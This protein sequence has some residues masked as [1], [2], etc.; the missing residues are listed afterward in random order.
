MQTVNKAVIFESG[1]EEYAVPIESV[2]SIEKVDFINPIP[3]MPL[4]MKGIT[5]IR[6]ELVPVID[7][8]AVLYNQ[9]LVEVE[10]ARLLV[11]QTHS[12]PAGF[13]VKDAKEI[14]DIPQES[15]K[16][17]GLAAY[18]KTKYFT[19]VAAFSERLVTVINPDILVSSLEG[20]KD[21]QDYMS[22]NKVSST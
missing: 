1:R 19:G 22:K 11:V 10:E 20:M 4:Y 21:I 16:Q 13:L 3:H 8:E 5:K 15:L 14:I 7:V 17:M 6:E 2:I 12:L 9:P 18:E